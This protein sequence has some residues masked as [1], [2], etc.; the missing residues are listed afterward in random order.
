MFIVFVLITK[1]ITDHVIGDDGEARKTLD[2]QIS[3]FS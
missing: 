3:S 1:S 2:M